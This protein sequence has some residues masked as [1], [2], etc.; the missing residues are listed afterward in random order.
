MALEEVAAVTSPDRPKRRSE[1][2]AAELDTNRKVTLEL[3]VQSLSEGEVGLFVAM[4][5][6][7]TGLRELLVMRLAFEAGNAASA[8]R[9]RLPYR[10]SRTGSRVNIPPGADGRWPWDPAALPLHRQE[11]AI[12]E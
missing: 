8:A 4:F 6:R 1:T 11:C 9:C 2:L 12:K 10:N 3:P 7:F 5:R